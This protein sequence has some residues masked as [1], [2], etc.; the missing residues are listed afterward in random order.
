ML[1]SVCHYI[2]LHDIALC[3]MFF[4]LHVC[5]MGVT[6]K[7][8]LIVESVIK[9]LYTNMHAHNSYST[10]CKANNALSANMPYLSTVL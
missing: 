4:V 5:Y 10:A 2:S 9:H 8:W 7:S 3:S 6:L 1:V